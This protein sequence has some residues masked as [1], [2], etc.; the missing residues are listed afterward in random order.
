MQ[1]KISLL[2]SSWRNTVNGAK[3]YF[4]SWTRYWTHC[5]RKRGFRLLLTI[6]V[7][8]ETISKTDKVALQQTINHNFLLK[9]AYLSFS[10]SELIPTVLSETFAIINT[11]QGNTQQNARRTLDNDWKPLSYTVVPRLFWREEYMFFKQHYKQVMP[12]PLLATFHPFKF[13]QKIAWV[14]DFNV[15]SFISSIYK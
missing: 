10:P 1:L 2:R 15:L 12:E 11:Q 7:L 4:S 5:N 3:L 9:Y 8:L 13:P 6:L 14:H